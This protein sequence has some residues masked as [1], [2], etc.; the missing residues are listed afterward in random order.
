MTRLIPQLHQWAANTGQDGIGNFIFMQDGAPCHKAKAVTKYLRD[1]GIVVLD[2][3]GNSP[4]INPIEKMWAIMKKEMRKNVISNKTK[5]IEELI[6]VWFRS[7][8]IQENCKKLIH[9]MPERV[10]AVIKA[11]GGFTKF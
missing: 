4:D 3:P 8:E 6:R 2:W 9:S 5:L 1:E 11:K 7:P 10:Q